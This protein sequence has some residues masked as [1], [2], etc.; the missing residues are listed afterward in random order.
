MGEIKIFKFFTLL[1]IFGFT[2]TCYSQGSYTLSPSETNE[3]CNKGSAG[4]QITGLQ[5]NDTLTVIWSTGQTGVFS[6]GN[7]NAGNY[8]VHVTIKGKLDSTINITVGKEDCL[9]YISKSFTPNSDNYNDFWQ[10]SNTEYYPN[11]ELFV[12]NK[13]GQQ[14]HSERGTYTPW[15]GKWNGINAPDG[16]YYYVFY[17]DGGNKNKLLKGDVTVLR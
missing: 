8:S 16:T 15:D 7:L 12:F 17:Y 11:F 6:I 10:I 2:F 13:W 14:V 5:T 4:I 3:G 1:I 9:V